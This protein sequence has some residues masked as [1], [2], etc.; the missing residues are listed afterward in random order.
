M[1]DVCVCCVIIPLSDQRIAYSHSDDFTSNPALNIASPVRSATSAPGGGCI[2][3][4]GAARSV[5]QLKGKVNKLVK[6]KARD[7]AVLGDLLKSNC[8]FTNACTR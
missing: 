4:G 5:K 1:Q 2:S 7:S 6:P 3:T 8:H